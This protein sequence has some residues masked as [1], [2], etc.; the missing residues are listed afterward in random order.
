MLFLGAA[1]QSSSND[2]IGVW[3]AERNFG[4]AV[5]SDVAAARAGFNIQPAS[6]AGNAPFAVP[7]RFHSTL[8]DTQHFYLVVQRRTDGTTEAFFRNPE[9]NAGAGIGTRTVIVDGS[10]VRLQR[11]NSKD[12]IGGLDQ[13]GSLHFQFQGRPGDF[14]FQKGATSGFYP[15]A[16]VTSYVYRK[17]DV[18]ADGWRTGTLASVGLDSKPI[19]E[20]INLIVRTPTDSLRAPYIQSVQIERHGKLVLD[21]Y[22]YGFDAQR[23]HDVR[24]AAKSVTTLLIGR[25]IE[26]RLPLTPSSP[27]LP[28]FPQ[29]APFVNDDARKQHMTVANLMTMSSGLAC[30]DNDDNSPGNEDAMQSQT[31]Q[32]DWYKYTLDLPMLYEP[33]AR[34]IYCSAGINLLGGILTQVTRQWLP[35][36][37]DEHF[38]RPMQFGTYGLWLTAPPPQ[39]AYMAG[40]DYFR[41][42]DFLKFGQLFL[43]HGRWDGRKIID[44]NWLKQSATARTAPE[45]EG[46]RYGYGWHLFDYHVGSKTIHAVSAGGNGGQILVIM[47]QL[48]MAV[49][50]TAGNYGQFPVWRTYAQA[51]VPHYVVAAA[52]K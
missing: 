13:N 27:V 3:S 45:G 37:F 50:M 2:L 24:S 31:Q 44:E 5:Q 20:L 29:Y 21:E 25:A 6:S 39:T 47:P 46:D 48:D 26:D 32:P 23:P 52:V 40:G 38:A 22:F 42:R 9:S 49:M 14:V 18:L 4:P 8:Q 12:V 11:P 43:N 41:P 51:L 34:S 15:R 10:T 19:L 28:F 33:G 16:G 30:D 35:S 7:Q 36:Y 17:P 1:S